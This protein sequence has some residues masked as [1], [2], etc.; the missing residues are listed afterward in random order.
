MKCSQ[1]NNLNFKGYDARHLNAVLVTD[2]G[3]GGG[4]SRELKEIGQK[5]NFDVLVLTKDGVT[6]ISQTNNIPA[7][8]AS[9]PWIQDYVLFTPN[10]KILIDGMRLKFLE[11]LLKF[12]KRTVYPI[13]DYLKGGNIFF[14]KS[15]N[16]TELLVGKDDMTRN[17]LLSQ[18]KG[19]EAIKD[20]F[21]IDKIISVPQMDFHLDLS[22]RPLDKKR[23]LIADDNMML[24]ILKQGAEKV[25]KA[26]EKEDDDFSK[27]SYELLAKKISDYGD[28]FEKQMKVKKGAKTEDVEAVLKDNGYEVIRVPGR[29]YYVKDRETNH[30]VNFMNA[31][32]TINDKG[33]LVYITNKNSADTTYFGI[34]EKLAEKIGFSIENEFKESLKP[35]VKPEN[36][37]FVKGLCGEIQGGLEH[38]HGGI[39][40]LTTEI[41]N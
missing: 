37:Y 16:K 31:I 11:P 28:D 10:N 32:V 36:V 29:M 4:I 13:C 24:K 3:V 41:P 40:C 14:V 15:G 34:D 30:L 5:S 2:T 19:R 18:E 21:G 22:I 27:K 1:L 20:I 9:P 35:Y 39:H 23:V 38:A 12:F 6:N 33:E 7:V 17:F 26:A 25:Q 8:N